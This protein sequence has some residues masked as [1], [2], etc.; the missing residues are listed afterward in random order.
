MEVR[1]VHQEPIEKLPEFRLV[2]RPFEAELTIQDY[3]A[4]AQLKVSFPVG[5]QQRQRQS[6]LLD[7]EALLGERD[8]RLSFSLACLVAAGSLERFQRA[9]GITEVSEPHSDFL[10][11]RRR[12]SFPERAIDRCGCERWEGGETLAMAVEMFPHRLRV[13]SR[14]ETHFVASRWNDRNLWGHLGPNSSSQPVRPILIY[15]L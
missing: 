3:R 12:W 10:K 7:S 11:E 4:R 1:L 2:I 6:G 13:S 9:I 5:E 14:E 15:S 8:E